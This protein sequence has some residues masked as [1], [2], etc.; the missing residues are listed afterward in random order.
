MDFDSVRVSTEASIPKPDFNRS[1]SSKETDASSAYAADNPNSLTNKSVEGTRKDSDS[2]NGDADKRKGD[3]YEYTSATKN[4][5]SKAV[6]Q[7][8]EK[9]KVVNK[10]FSYQLHEKTKQIM[11]K[12]MDTDS[13]EVIREIPP[14]ESLDM[15]A[16]MLEM[17]GVI[18]DEKR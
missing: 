15:I 10:E 6:D 16:R 7:A 18:V 8:N 5:M 17:S 11:V 14:K 12:V 13:G 3:G 2:K 9:L 1:N 4:S